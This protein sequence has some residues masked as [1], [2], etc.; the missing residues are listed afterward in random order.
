MQPFKSF[1]T[2]RLLLRPTTVEDADFILQLMNSPKWLQFIG[3]RNIRTLKNAQTYIASKMVPQYQRL[4]YSNYTVI[5][6]ADN[7]RMGSCG[8]YDRDGLEGIDLGFAFLPEYE[9]QGYAF[10]ASKRLLEAAV[11]QF[12]I[13]VLSAITTKNNKA[14]Q[15]LLKKLQFKRCGTVTLPSDTEELLL[16][17]FN[18]DQ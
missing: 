1:E 3:D 11:N 18:Q 13:T 2:K 14:S 7:I 15:R 5:R 16:F 6:K 10:E 8:L 4:G 12:T 17:L 9:G